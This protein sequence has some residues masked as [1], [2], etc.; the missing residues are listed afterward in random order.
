MAKTKVTILYSD[1]YYRPQDTTV[2]PRGWY[3]DKY[4]ETWR[5]YLD[6]EREVIERIPFRG[7]KSAKKFARKHCEIKEVK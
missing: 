6:I 5:N 4:R 2:A 3:V 1:A 7:E